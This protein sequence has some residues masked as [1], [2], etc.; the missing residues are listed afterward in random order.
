MEIT[1]LGGRLGLV[2]AV[3]P[4]LYKAWC[5]PVSYSLDVRRPAGAQV[6]S[7]APAASLAKTC[8]GPL[9]LHRVVFHES[10]VSLPLAAVLGVLF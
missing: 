8:L 5:S 1:T 3:P 4:V 9:P 10:C 7:I 6:K 2:L